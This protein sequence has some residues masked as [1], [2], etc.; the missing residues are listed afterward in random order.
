MTVER[1]HAADIHQA[2]GGF[3]DA[4]W[5]FSFGHYRDPARLGVGPLRV[6]NDDLLVPG[7]VW[8]MHPHADV[9]SLT[10]VV[11]GRFGHADSLGGGGELGPGGAQ[12]MTFGPGMAQHSER[13][14]DPDRRLRFLQFW[15]LPDRPNLDDALQQQ[16]FASADRTD[17]WC[18]IM[19]PRGEPGLDLHQDARIEVARLSAGATLELAN[20]PG[21]GRYCYVIDGEVAVTSSRGPEILVAGDA[22]DIRDLDVL[23]ITGRAAPSELWC[24]EVPLEAERHGIWAQMHE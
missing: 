12:V 18:T 11:E 24:A 6:F 3:F 14:L 13:N 5:H 20:A 8:P 7:G 9:E 4:R 15:I 17:R 22:L 19:S 16:Q 23:S 10:Y 1:R 2:S 21:R